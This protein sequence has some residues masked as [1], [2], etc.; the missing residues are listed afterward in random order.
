MLTGLNLLVPNFR[1]LL[2]SN[3]A[4]LRLIDPLL[5]GDELQVVSVA[6]YGVVLMLEEHE[7]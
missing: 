6:K 7:L 4:P 2:S 3:L 1:F 5:E